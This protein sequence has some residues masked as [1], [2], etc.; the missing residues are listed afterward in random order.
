MRILILE[1][2][3]IIAL[4]LQMLVEHCGHEVV[5]V[6]ETIAA[7]RAQLVDEPDFAFLDVDLPDGKSYEIASRLD[8]RR[9]PFCFVSGSRRSEMP[10]HLRHARFISKPYHHAAIRN[11]L[12]GGIRL[13]S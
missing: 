1:D 12:V 6:C 10:E 2:D 9:I 5:V 8:E 13:A 3:P 11:T 7:M 4:D